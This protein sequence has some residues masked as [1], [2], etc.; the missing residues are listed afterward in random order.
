MKRNLRLAGEW[1][2]THAEAI[3]NTTY[4][5]VTPE[6]GQAVRFTQTTEAFYIITLYA[7]N[8]TLVLESPVPYVSGDEVIVVGGNVSGTV[9][10][11]QVL[12]TGS[13]ELTISD[14]VREAD[15]Y[16]WVF[17]IPF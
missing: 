17:K 8:N 2:N 16:A 12:D 11:S 1:V 4:W 15:Q 14:E 7:P 3:F 13:L 5:Y 6:E 9:V 10:P